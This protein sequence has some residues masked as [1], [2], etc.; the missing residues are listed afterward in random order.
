MNLS[1]AGCVMVYTTFAN[2]TTLENAGKDVVDYIEMHY[3]GNRRHSLGNKKYI[4]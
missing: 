1:G 2:H 3:N 4:R